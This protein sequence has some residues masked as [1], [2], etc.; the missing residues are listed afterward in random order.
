MRCVCDAKD[1]VHG[2][3]E[4]DI[5]AHGNI[6]NGLKKPALG[7]NDIVSNQASWELGDVF[8]AAIKAFQTNKV[9]LDANARQYWNFAGLEP[10]AFPDP[11]GKTPKTQKDKKYAGYPLLKSLLKALGLH[12]FL[13]EYMTDYA[14]DASMLM[15][16]VGIQQHADK[17]KSIMSRPVFTHVDAGPEALKSTLAFIYYKWPDMAVPLAWHE[18][19]DEV[20]QSMSAPELPSPAASGAINVV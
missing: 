6:I 8:K 1:G 5:A 20:K 13:P 15:S 4:K 18:V 7:E 11:E 16:E 10:D 17:K 14:E 9:N 19:W 2:I 3:P 12:A